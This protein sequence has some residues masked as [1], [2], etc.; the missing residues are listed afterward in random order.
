[1]TT[2][3]AMAAIVSRRAL[4]D[5]LSPTGSARDLIADIDA[6]MRAT[7]ALAQCDPRSLLAACYALARTGLGLGGG[8]AHLIPRQGQATLQVSAV[9]MVE[10]ARRYGG[11]TTYAV[12]V[13]HEGD[14]YDYDLGTSPRLTHR[15][16][17]RDR[18]EPLAA[19]AVLHIADAPPIVEIALWSEVEA[20]KRKSKS[21][22]WKDWPEQMAVRLPLRRAAKRA[23]TSP[24]ARDAL[25]LDGAGEAETAT[26]YAREAHAVAAHAEAH[27]APETTT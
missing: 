3:P 26:D 9:G 13:M 10:L 20:V 23:C 12:G 18:G 21:P 17:L 24:A 22:A 6:A 4:L 5:S 2:N 15:P 8:H 11:A 25:A 19:Y 27:T 14:A 7:P 16:A 1:M